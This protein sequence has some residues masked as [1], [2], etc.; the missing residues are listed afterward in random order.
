MA[1][2]KIACLHIS[3][4]GAI[5][6]S[7]KDMASFGRAILSNALV[8]PVITR[9]WL[10]PATH[11]S[12]LRF[13]V[14]APWEIYSFS[15]PRRIDL[16]TKAG[17]I[18]MYS[19]FLGLSPD[20]DAGFTVLVAGENSHQMTSTISE[21]VADILLPSLDNVAKNQALERFV[22]TYALTSD[23]FNSSITITA[24][25]GP[26][27]RVEE[28][29]SNSVDMYETL[30][31]LQHVTDRS[32]IS[33]RLQPNGLQTSDRVGFSGVIYALPI[34]PNTGPILGSC[35]SWIAL[36]S[37]I[38]A[39]IGLSEFEFGLDDRG[40]AMSISPRALRVTLPRL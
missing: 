30:M 3:S 28:W 10:K 5:F 11:T 6:S 22:G 2:I 1:W 13:S 35:I 19:S 12:S 4:A 24:D 37:L 20:H 29:I 36:E 38:Y 33:I 7:P 32:A 31:T 8:D 34:P 27:L 9:R 26:G 16:Y 23:T 39:N 18:G 17:D 21:L 14:G 25:D 40:D 15:T